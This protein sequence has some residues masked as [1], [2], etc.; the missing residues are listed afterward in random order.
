[1]SRSFD[2]VLL[3][4]I[5]LFCKAAELG[6]FTAAAEALGVT[7]AAVSRSV[8][9]LE[10][11][12]GLRLFVRT[13]R[14]VA[15]TDDGRVYFEQCREALMQIELA[16]RAITEHQVVPSGVLRI[17]VPTTYGHYRVLPCLPK[18]TARYPLIKIDISISNR[19]VDFVEEGFDLAIRMGEPQDS[20]LIARKLEDATLGVF[21][22]P[23]YLKRRGI[24][25]N[26]DDLQ[27]HDCVQ[28]I[29]PSTGR[30]MS[31]IFHKDGADVDFA[32]E[33]QV[34]CQE[35]V[36]GCVTY[37]R[38]GGGC[39]QIYHYIAQDAVTRGEL[40][41]ILQPFGGRSRPFSMLYP[42]NRHLSAKI[43][44]FIDFLAQEV[45]AG[46]MSTSKRD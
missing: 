37:A 42:Q 5:E 46:G 16:E 9:R 41:E 22:S 4:S 25:K 11:R 1:M 33:S 45:H 30:P 2:P 12:L 10:D 39:F 6:N 29:F 19:V 17:S 20:R 36:L 14:R 40:V 8:G 21:A 18:F 24:P 38:A 13:T 31:W 23:G 34:R 28:F 35:D 44:V 26:L 15:L 7:P 43:R 3:G 32:F 27:R